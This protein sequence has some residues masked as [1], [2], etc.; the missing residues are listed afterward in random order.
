MFH[1]IH[2]CMHISSFNS[3]TRWI[4]DKGSK[5]WVIHT[6]SISSK[7]TITY[8]MERGVL[9]KASLYRKNMTVSRRHNHLLLYEHLNIFLWG[10]FHQQTGWHFFK[11][12]THCGAHLDECQWQG[13]MRWGI[14]LWVF[15]PT[16]WLSLFLMP[17][18]SWCPSNECQGLMAPLFD[19]FSLGL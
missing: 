1:I 2:S 3:S 6:S 10:N 17:D 14:T 18:N 11:C 19:K 5:R 8:Q 13:P 9:I 16:K 7:G 4:G 15:S 12:Q